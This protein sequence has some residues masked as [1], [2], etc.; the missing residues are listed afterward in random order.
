MNWEHLFKG[1]DVK[2][3][4]KAYYNEY[5]LENKGKNAVNRK[6]LKKKTI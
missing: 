2:R 6:K 5:I 3:H 1:S 4:D